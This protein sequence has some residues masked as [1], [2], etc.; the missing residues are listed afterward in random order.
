VTPWARRR[1]IRIASLWGPLLVIGIL[2]IL[3]ASL[4]WSSILRNETLHEKFARA[5]R[6]GEEG[7]AESL[8]WLIVKKKPSDIEAWVRFIDAHAEAHPPEDEI[9]IYETPVASE[10][11]IRALL[12]RTGDPAVSA[13]A[14]HWYERSVKGAKPDEAQLVALADRHPPARMANYLLG[15]AAA[16]RRE[17]PLAARRYEREGLSFAEDRDHYLRGAVDVWMRIDDWNAVRQRAGDG[18][19][20]NVF[21]SYM[22][23][24]LAIHD[25]DWPRILLLAWPA[26]FSGW[27]VWPVALA[28]LAAVLWFVI[29]TRLGRVHDRIP[30]RAGL[31]ILSFVLG[32]ISIG[33]TLITILFEEEVLG[34]R[35]LGQFVPG[36]IYFIFGVGLREEAWKLILFLPLLPALL[37]RGSRIEAMTCGALV[38]LGFAAEENIGYFHEYGAAA[39]L[40][41]FL[42]ANFLHMSLTALVALSVFDT[43]RGRATPSDG[44]S[45]V[46]PMAVIIHGAYDFF[47]TTD[48]VPLSSII[49]MA[50]FIVMARQFL[51]Q[52]TIASSREE[53][54]GVLY[55]LI[56]SLSL[57]T[58][59][60]YV[61]AT[62][63][64]GPWYAM[65]L[66]SVGALGVAI[67]LWMFVRELSP[68]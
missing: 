59:V 54:Q 10:P 17:W 20:A 25:R 6:M 62:T 60:A 35:Q 55:L 36:A 45:T 68:D 28:V 11:A 61:Y 50:L 43:K 37:R 47:L 64:V 57:I 22:R 15:R 29:A 2:S 33:P 16:D 40:S 3:A 67:V 49:S 58:G 30:G 39:A 18:R 1:L 42:T 13:V 41:R 52:L 4:T 46:F 32:V 12:T 8:S 14:A 38:G 7:E 63:L 26:G 9:E 21:D 53:E 66:M 65:G 31:Y 27:Q 24:E 5:A 19:Y 56:A 23:L 44:F 51:R 34:L 48:D